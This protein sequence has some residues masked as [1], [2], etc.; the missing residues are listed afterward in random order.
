[1]WPWRFPSEAG[2]GGFEG[3]AEGQAPSSYQVE[4]LHLAAMHFAAFALVS[5]TFFACDRWASLP[6]AEQEACGWAS[7]RRFAR[8]TYRRPLDAEEGRRLEAFWQVN[9]AAGPLDEA[10]ALTVA[11]L[12]QT[13]TFHFRIEPRRPGGGAGA[14]PLS[15]WQLASRLSYFLWDSMPDEA[16]FAA[17]EAG[18]L[19]T[20][21]GIEAQARRMLDDPKPGPPSSASTTSGS[22]PTMSCWSRRPAGR[23]ARCSASKPSWPPRATTTWNGR[24]SWGR[25]ATR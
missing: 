25:C 13:P 19:D 6:P 15:R 24:P 21:A 14:R 7:L 20:R 1:M 17:A 12:L 16:L 3:I 2:S 10:V 8:R 5:P 23:S 4:E 22:A 11:G 18:D 9:A